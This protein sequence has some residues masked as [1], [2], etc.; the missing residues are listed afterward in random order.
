MM[1]HRQ[2]WTL[3]NETGFEQNAVSFGN[4]LQI[5]DDSDAGCDKKCHNLQLLR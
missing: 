1:A 2:L 5:C 3:Q 4:I